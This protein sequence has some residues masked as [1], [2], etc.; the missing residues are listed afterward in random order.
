MNCHKYSQNWRESSQAQWEDHFRAKGITESIPSFSG[1]IASRAMDA[2]YFFASQGF[3]DFSGIELA[4]IINLDKWGPDTSAHC[5]AKLYGTLSERYAAYRKEMDELQMPAIHMLRIETG[6]HRGNL[7]MWKG[8]AVNQTGRLVDKILS[9]PM[10]DLEVSSEDWRQGIR[11]PFPNEVDFRVAKLFGFYWA[12]G[13]MCEQGKNSH[14]LSL[15]GKD[16]IKDVLVNEVTP[17]MQEVHNI[18]VWDDDQ[19]K[20]QVT[21]ANTQASVGGYILNKTSFALTSFLMKEHNFPSATKLRRDLGVRRQPKDHLPNIPWNDETIDGFIVGLIKS[22]GH[23]GTYTYAR[24]T[25]KK[26]ENLDVISIRGNGEYYKELEPLLQRRGY[27]YSVGFQR[28]SW[29]I[30]LNTQPTLHFRELCSV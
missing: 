6:N 17:L 24:G 21:F 12:I 30:F 2:G 14:L 3:H 10:F 13:S 23:D 8:Y 25:A 18:H 11:L 28:N 9:N 29:V 19:Q 26:L 20:R 1:T 4:A 16:T 5:S 27:G 22:R 15:S 7:H